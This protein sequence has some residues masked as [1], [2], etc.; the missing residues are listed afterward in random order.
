MLRTLASLA[1]LMIASAGASRAQSPAPDSTGYAVDSSGLNRGGTVTIRADR[2][3]SDD[4]SVDD[5]LYRS[6]IQSTDATDVAAVMYEVPAA[7]VQVNSRGEANLYLRNA[8]ERQVSLFFDGALLNIPWDNR[9]DLS[10]LP[11][12]AVGGMLVSKGTPSVLYGANTMGGAVNIVTRSMQGE[13][14]QTIVELGGGQFGEVTG[15]GTHLARSGRLEFFASGSYARRDAIALPENAVVP[16]NQIGTDGRTNTDARQAGLFLR[17]GYTP[18]EGD[19]IAVSLNVVDAHKGVAPEGHLDATVDRVRF[20][21]YPEWRWIMTNLSWGV[22]SGEYGDW[23]FQGALWNTWFSQRIDQYADSTYTERTDQQSDRDHVVGTRMIL[24]T[25]G[26][27]TTVAVGTTHTIARHDQVDASIRNGATQVDPEQ[28]YA[29]YVGSLG[30]EVR[31]EVA[32]GIGLTA[33]LSIDVMATLAAADKPAQE[34]FVEPGMSVAAIW[35]MSDVS[36][37]GAS[38]GRKSRFPS[39]REL[40]GEALNRFLV[41]PELSP[42]SAYAAELEF[43]REFGS[44]SLSLTAFGQSVTN[45]IDQ[46]SVIVDSVRKRQRYNLPGSTVIGLEFGA[47]VRATDWLRFDGHLTWSR[48]RTSEPLENG[49]R[50]LSE[51]PDLIGTATLRAD[52]PENL[53]LDLE[54]VHVGQAYTLDQQ[55]TFVPLRRSTTLNTRLSWIRPSV[56]P[57]ALLEIYGRVNNLVATST[58]SQLGLPGPGRSARLGLRL[59]L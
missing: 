59:T 17:G 47:A 22:T 29:Q 58:L 56:G 49:A 42:E 20:W 33:G 3:R 6:D 40:Y 41:N 2:L 1:L 35:Q 39:M 14:S 12:T 37:L 26:E 7:R 24:A 45:T 48:A 18:G 25:G 30:P 57:I 43:E 28:S 27:T 10:L 23:R 21:R 55:N 11:L 5:A 16:Y 32:D 13:G 46:R 54:G 44:S 9:V 52:L 53:R 36:A 50:Y 31:T 4:I 8:G 38:F 34:P 15:S 19:E 51:K